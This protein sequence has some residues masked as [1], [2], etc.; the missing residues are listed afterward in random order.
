[1]TEAHKQIIATKPRSFQNYFL[2]F[3]TMKNEGQLQMQGDQQQT[4]GKRKRA[5]IGG[6]AACDDGSAQTDH[7]N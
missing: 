3:Y 5:S 1:M 7:C 6:G 4:D 2:L